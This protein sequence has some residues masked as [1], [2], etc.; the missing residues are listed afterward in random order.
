MRSR[1]TIK[2]ELEE[3]PGI[4][5]VRQRELLRFFGS[6]ERVKE[7]TVKELAQAPKMNLKSAQILYN[8]FHSN[9]K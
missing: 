7:A 6:A 8:F 3:I 2:S 4:G 1:E 9:Q 5:A